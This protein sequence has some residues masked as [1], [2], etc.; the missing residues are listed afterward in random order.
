M[1]P[2]PLLPIFV[3]LT[4]ARVPSVCLVLD[5]ILRCLSWRYRNNSRMRFSFCRISY[6]Y[7]FQD[8]LACVAW[9]NIS[10][11]GMGKSWVDCVAQRGIGNPCKGCIQEGGWGGGGVKGDWTDCWIISW[12]YYSTVVSFCLVRAGERAN[13]PAYYTVQ[14]YTTRKISMCIIYQNN[15]YSVFIASIT[16]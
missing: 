8:W 5:W 14:F 9:A 10:T 7:F 15:G 2:Q 11:T 13:M 4:Q 1:S 6:H 3:S 12:I 16:A